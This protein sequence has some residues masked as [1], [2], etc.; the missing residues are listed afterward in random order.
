[1]EREL[2]LDGLTLE[3]GE[4]LALELE[5]GLVDEL[6]DT[7]EETELDGDTEGLVEEEGEIDGD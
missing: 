6:G 3:L 1:M 5:D 2:E 7:D 4:I